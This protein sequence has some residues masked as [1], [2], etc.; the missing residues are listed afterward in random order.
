MHILRTAGLLHC[1]FRR[2]RWSRWWNKL[3]PTY[4]LNYVGASK[5]MTITLCKKTYCTFKQSSRKNSQFL[6]TVSTTDSQWKHD[7]NKRTIKLVRNKL[8]PAANCARNYR[9]MLNDVI[10]CV[11]ASLS[12]VG[13]DQTQQLKPA[14]CAITRRRLDLDDKNEKYD[15]SLSTQMLRIFITIYDI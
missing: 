9:D 10:G 1:V 3:Q 7:K 4:K 12:K 6:I 13:Y 8:I 2:Q 15:V 14:T 11:W 5:R